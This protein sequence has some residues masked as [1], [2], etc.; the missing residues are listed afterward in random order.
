MTLHEAYQLGSDPTWRG[1]CQTAGLQAAAN[2]MSE[3]PSTAGHDL[4]I[5]YA[6]T[7]MLNPSLQSQAIAFGVAAQPGISGPEATDQDILFT[8]NSLWDAW[9]GVGVASSSR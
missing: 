8:C 1:R 4:R 9:S 3:D 6:N 2:V 5:E 7:V